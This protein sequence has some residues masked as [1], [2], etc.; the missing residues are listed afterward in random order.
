MEEWR[1]TRWPGKGVCD[2][3][4]YFLG[5]ICSD[6]QRSRRSVSKQRSKSFARA[7]RAVATECLICEMFKEFRQFAAL[8][9]M[10]R[11]N[12]QCRRTCPDSSGG[13]ALGNDVGVETD[14][15]EMSRYTT[16]PRTNATT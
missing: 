2:R 3:G 5:S 12:S 13:N 14:T 4:G 8:W 16:P 6:T 1:Q 10:L 9:K 7:C 11:Q 15:G